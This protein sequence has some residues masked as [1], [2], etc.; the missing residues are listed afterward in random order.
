[1]PYYN[2]DPN[3]DH[4]FDNHPYKKDGKHNGSYYLGLIGFR[5]KISKLG[6]RM[7]GE[8]SI[9]YLYSDS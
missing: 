5:V 1:M 6:T 8:S 9:K 3:R 2:R 4:N 7:M